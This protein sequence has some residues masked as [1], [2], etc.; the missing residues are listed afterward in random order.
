[1]TGIILQ[2]IGGFYTVMDDETG[3]RYQLRAQAKIRRERLTPLV[4]D[5]VEYEPAD[6]EDVDGW[7][8]SILPRK[9]ALVRPS[10]AN[11]DEIV[12][13]CASSSPKADTLLMDRLLISAERAGMNSSIVVNK[14]DLDAD[15]ARA[16][17]EE[18]RFS[19]AKVFLTSAKTGEGVSEI[20][21]HLMGKVHAFG[22]QSGVGKSSLI[23]ALYALSLSTGS[24]SS[25]IERGKHTTRRCELIPVAGGGSVLDTPGF[26]LLETELMEPKELQMF[27]PELRPFE[28]K[29]R[30]SPCFH[31]GEPDCLAKQA[32]LRG[33]I[34]EK[35]YERYL[36]LL[37][38]M[39]E[40]WKNRYD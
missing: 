25:R 30:F 16:L 20:K 7:L 34:P 10:V 35:R 19:G 23:N 9:N 3:E 40:R 28:G 11:I 4:G 15:E 5:R 27:Y 1:M 18:Y 21:E 31:A 33:E 38:E 8:K 2:G 17:A 39:K 26:S 14:A 36:E 12:V 37:N 32:L 29:C 13:V 6:R 22:G 24:V